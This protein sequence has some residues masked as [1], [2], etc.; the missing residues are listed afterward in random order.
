M[1]LLL[2]NIDFLSNTEYALCDFGYRRPLTVK[3]EEFIETLTRFTDEALPTELLKEF[4]V[5][6]IWAMLD[7]KVF[8]TI[9]RSGTSFYFD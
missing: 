4:Y 3:F 8:I 6:Y 1:L 2:C 7:P 9:L 5:M